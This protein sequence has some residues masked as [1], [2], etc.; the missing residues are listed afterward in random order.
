MR[1]RTSS[2]RFRNQTRT[3]RYNGRNNRVRDRIEGIITGFVV[4]AISFAVTFAMCG[5]AC[6]TWAEHPAEQA[7]SGREYIETLEN[8]GANHAV[9]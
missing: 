5:M 1:Q 2:E 3:R 9:D 4:L 7:V 8:W 6:K